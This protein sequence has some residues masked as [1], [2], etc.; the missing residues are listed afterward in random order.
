VVEGATMTTAGA[1]VVAVMT[2]TAVAGAAKAGTAKAG[3][4]KAAAGAAKVAAVT[5]TS[6]GAPPAA[7]LLRPDTSRR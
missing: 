1:V 7:V 2:M 5:M 4:A 3:T 6:L